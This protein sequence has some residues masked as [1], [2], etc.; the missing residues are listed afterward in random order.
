MD[1]TF[2]HLETSRKRSGKTLGRIE[3]G[4]EE[5]FS[6]GQRQYLTPHGEGGGKAGVEK[7]NVLYAQSGRTGAAVK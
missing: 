1:T 7:N 5:N 3:C 4:E 6:V 2:D